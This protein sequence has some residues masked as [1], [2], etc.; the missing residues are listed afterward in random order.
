MTTEELTRRWFKLLFG[1]GVSIR[2]HVCRRAFFDRIHG[3]YTFVALVAS[4]AAVATLLKG[5]GGTHDAAAWLAGF[6]SVLSAINLVVRPSEKARAHHD[7]VRRFTDIERAMLAIEQPTQEDYAR[8]ANQ[9]IALDAE[10][11]PTKTYLAAI[12]HNESIRAMGLD[13][14][15]AVPIGALRRSMAHFTNIGSGKLEKRNR[16]PSVAGR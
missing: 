4:S 12:C 8:I 13:S 5:N 16:T 6:V 7:F 9:R 10:E 2:Y 11:P 14:G 15:D 1:V 3:S